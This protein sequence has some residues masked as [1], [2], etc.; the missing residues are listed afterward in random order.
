M[1]P[2]IGDKATLTIQGK[3]EAEA[4]LVR[5]KGR[6]ATFR[7]EDGTEVTL[8]LSSHSQN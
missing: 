7:L 3:G 8:Q 2:K 6:I 1:F 4:T 5:L